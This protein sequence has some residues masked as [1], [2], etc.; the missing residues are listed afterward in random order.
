MTPSDGSA[1]F[2]SFIAFELGFVAQLFLIL[3]P[4]RRDLPA[5]AWT[6]LAALVVALLPSKGEG[7]YSVGVHLLMSI[8]WFALFAAIRFRRRL[9]PWLQEG[10]LLVWNCLFV[11]ALLL[12]YGP[13]SLLA[14]VG[15]TIAALVVL[16]IVLPVVVPRVLQ[17]LLYGWYLVIIVWLAMLQLRSR[18]GSFLSGSDLGE[19]DPA[20]AFLDG[21]AGIYILFHLTY[22]TALVPLKSKRQSWARALKEWREDADTVIRRFSDAQI[23]PLLATMVVAVLAI[24]FTANTLRP[25]LQ[26]WTLVNLL[27]IGTPWWVRGLEW[28]RSGPRRATRP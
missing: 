10:V 24:A 19:V 15:A 16:I 23:D 7:T 6:A 20:I 17:F 11:Y 26:P 21:M 22:L 5:L 18:E 27:L 8:P 13:S 14:R 3:R 25:T 1:F 2:Q 4:R 12:V 28:L 9:L